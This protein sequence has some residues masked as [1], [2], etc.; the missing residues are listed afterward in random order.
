MSIMSGAYVAS[1]KDI[2]EARLSWECHPTFEL[3][4]LGALLVCNHAW[5][6]SHQASAIMD[7]NQDNSIAQRG[8]I[9]GT[10][11]VVVYNTPIIAQAVA[12]D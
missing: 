12:V 7:K 2:P 5:K 10:C 6:Q 9:S 8:L 4:A 3:G 1:A 11:Q